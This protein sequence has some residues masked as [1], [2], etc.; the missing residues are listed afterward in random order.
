MS[1][2]IHLDVDGTEAHVLWE[3]PGPSAEEE[4]CLR[5]L[6]R[7]GKKRMDSEPKK[8]LVREPR[9]KGFSEYTRF[10]CTELE[11]HELPHRTRSGREWF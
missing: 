5:E 10:P 9:R 4:D 6:I 11:G 3:G 8:C 7:V 1:R 2:C